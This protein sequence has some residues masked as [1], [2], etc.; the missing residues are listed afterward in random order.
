MELIIVLAKRPNASVLVVVFFAKGNILPLVC[1]SLL[2]L[3]NDSF[4]PVFD[5]TI[6]TSRTRAYSL[7]RSPHKI[8]NT[9]SPSK[10]DYNTRAPTISRW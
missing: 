1:V 8:G 9:V 7:G 3:A 5:S 10:N 6:V 4:T 2:S